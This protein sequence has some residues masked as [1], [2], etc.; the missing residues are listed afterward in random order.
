MNL[1]K[2]RRALIYTVSV[3]V[4]VVSRKPRLLQGLIDPIRH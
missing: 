1:Q 3:T 4:T 2:E